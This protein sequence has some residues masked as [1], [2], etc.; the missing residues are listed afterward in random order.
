MERAP[1]TSADPC[2]PGSFPRH[3]RYQVVFLPPLHFSEAQSRAYNTC[4]GIQDSQLMSHILSALE[5]ALTKAADPTCKA[6]EHGST[7][8]APR[9]HGP[10][11]PPSSAR[12]ARLPAALRLGRGAG[13]RRL[14]PALRLGRPWRWIK[15]GQPGRS[16]LVPIL[17]GSRGRADREPEV[18]KRWRDGGGEEGGRG[19]ERGEEPVLAGVQLV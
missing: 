8:S 10:V 13:L 7:P 11:C 19:E 5:L 1:Y 4:E 2:T 16:G 12:P 9:R 14:A 6:A 15:G 18:A 3:E 17:G